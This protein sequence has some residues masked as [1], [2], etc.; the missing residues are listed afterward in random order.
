MDLATDYDRNLT[1]MIEKNLIQRDAVRVVWTSEP[2]P[3]DPL[4]VR[5]GLDPAM[6]RTVQETIAAISEEDAKTVMPAHYTGWV[7][8][9]HASYKLIED[10]GIAVGKIKAK[11]TN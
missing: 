6:I 9:S 8:A 3:N 7:P 5:K 2:L 10:A 4:V 11:P 1:S